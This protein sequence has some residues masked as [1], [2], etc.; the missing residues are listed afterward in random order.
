M[1]IFIAAK[2]MEK[3]SMR[4]GQ[5]QKVSLSANQPGACF[6][7]PS[8]RGTEEKVTRTPCGYLVLLRLSF[9][10]LPARYAL[11]QAAAGRY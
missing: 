2:F 5:V 11:D 6:F 8:V 4:Q 3:L 1:F 10:Q 7:H 9:H